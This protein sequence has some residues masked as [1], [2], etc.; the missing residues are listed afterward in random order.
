MGPLYTVARKKPALGVQRVSNADKLV[1]F[2]TQ[3]TLL[4]VWKTVAGIGAPFARVIAFYVWGGKS[5][6]RLSSFLQRLVLKVIGWLSGPAFPRSN[7]LRQW[8]R[9]YLAVDFRRWH[10]GVAAIVAVTLVSKAIQKWRE[11]FDEKLRLMTQLREK[12]KQVSSYAEWQSLAHQLDKLGN[13]EKLKDGRMNSE[14]LFDRQLLQGKLSHLR[15]VRHMGNVREIMFAL[16]TDLLRNVANIAKSQ[17]HEYYLDAP[18]LIKDY[19]AEV[20]EQLCMLRD[21]PEQGLVLEEKLAF[22]RETRHA[23]GRTAL[24]LSGGGGLGSFHI[25]VCKALFEHQLLP[26]VMAGSSVGSIVAAIIATRT[27]EELKDT[28]SKLDQFD[29]GFFKN[30]KAV[31]LAFHL[32]NRGTLQNIDFLVNKLRILLGDLTF[33][34]AYERTGRILNVSVCPADTNEPARL[35]NYLTAPQ[36][37][38]WSAVAASSAFPGLFPAQHLLAKNARGEIVRFSA[39]AANGAMER[40]WRDGSL[41]LDLPTHLLAEMFNCNHF[42]VSQTNPHIVPLLNL[43]KRFTYKWANLFEIELKHRCQQLQYILPEWVPTKWLTLF[44]QPWEG[45]ITMVLPHTAWHVGKAIINPT[46]EELVGAVKVG[47]VATW[48]KL[49]AIECNCAIEVTLDGCVAHLTNRARERPLSSLGS[50]VPSWLHM[51][52]I[53]TPAVASWGE[54]IPEDGDNAEEHVAAVP[55]DERNGQYANGVGASIPACWAAQE[56]ADSV[57]DFPSGKPSGSG[58]APTGAGDRTDASSSSG[59]SNSEGASEIIMMA[60]I[61]CCDSSIQDLWSSFLPLASTS[62]AWQSVVEGSALDVIAP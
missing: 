35:L 3:L 46:T 32:I 15:R 31:D 5:V 28:F 16:R 1:N 18:Q 10:V 9:Y 33:L 21:W 39:T 49:S 40:R 37:L 51:S 42:L 38:M 24:L 57:A 59:D 48:E 8:G 13:A 53:G 29:I 54:P 23:F 45:D 17:L 27:D 36:A 19:I 50:R 4:A 58:S 55:G 34:E 44:T 52:H 43:K 12:M 47:E 26:R 62:V 30:S 14:K 2:I 61:D 11:H 41:E 56:C 6:Y 25:G 20:R 22:F 60:Q 7:W